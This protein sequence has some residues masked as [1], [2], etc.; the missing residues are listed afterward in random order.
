MPSPLCLY[1]WMEKYA[2]TYYKIII[3]FPIVSPSVS[4][5]FFLSH[6]CG[7]W[8]RRNRTRIYGLLLPSQAKICC[9]RLQW[10]LPSSIAHTCTSQG[11]HLNFKCAQSDI[12][13]KY[14]QISVS[15]IRIRSSL[16]FS[17]F[18]WNVNDMNWYLLTARKCWDVKTSS[19]LIQFSH[20]TITCSLYGEALRFH[21]VSGSSNHFKV[22]LGA[23]ENSTFN[24]VRHYAWA[25]AISNAGTIVE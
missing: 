16:T 3:H 4:F 8:K 10:A 19:Y 25:S 22:K 23:D 11:D 18:L 2:A 7:W 21:S 17:V 9:E 6:T 12:K 5:S 20:R 24:Y 13:M 14:L 1:N 15:I